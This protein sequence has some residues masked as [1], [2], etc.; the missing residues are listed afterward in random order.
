MSVSIEAREPLLDHKIIEFSANIPSAL[1][2]K[3]KTGK[4][5]LKEVLYKHIPKELIER[6]KSGFQIPLDEWL[7]SDLRDVLDFYLDSKK[8]DESGV[9]HV[10]NIMKL[11]DD[12]YQGKSVNISLLWFVLMFE[13]WREKWL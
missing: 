8:L 2:Y 11:K 9:F 4:Y 5:L 10:H 7:K 12:Y 3:N 6:P 13:M 1:K